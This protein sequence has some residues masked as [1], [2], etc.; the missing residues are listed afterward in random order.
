MQRKSRSFRPESLGA[1]EARVVMS[2][3]PAS[4]FRAVAPIQVLDGKF[5]KDIGREVDRAYQRFA[6]DYNRAWKSLMRQPYG[7]QDPAALDRLNAFAAR[8]G[9]QLANEQGANASRLRGSANYLAP[10]MRYH[11]YTMVDGLLSYGSVAE[12][13][14]AGRTIAAARAASRAELR[15]FVFAGIDSGDYALKGLRFNRAG[16]LVA[17]R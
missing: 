13:R 15:E 11:A 2:H 6:A 1:L 5:L 16:M 7:A 14:G 8:R 4:V 12:A 9:E 17:G 3:T 10:A